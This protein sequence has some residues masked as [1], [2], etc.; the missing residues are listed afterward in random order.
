MSGTVPNAPGEP[1]RALNMR[2][3]ASGAGAANNRKMPANQ[4]FNNWEDIG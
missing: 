3:F 2:P 1:R 4:H